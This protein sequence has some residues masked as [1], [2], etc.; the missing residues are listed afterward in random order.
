MAYRF[1]RSYHVAEVTNYI[2][3]FVVGFGFSDALIPSSRAVFDEKD[4]L[5]MA[6]GATV[7]AVSL[8]YRRH[9]RKQAT[10]DRVL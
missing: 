5:V 8:A 9:C 2:G 4:I 7:S 6:V 1:P 3:S 10:L